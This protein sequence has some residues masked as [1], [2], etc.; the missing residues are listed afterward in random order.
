MKTGGGSSLDAGAGTVEGTRAIPNRK[1]TRVNTQNTT[2]TETKNVHL[3][4]TSLPD[5]NDA[6]VLRI[7]LAPSRSISESDRISELI[8][9]GD[10]EDG[11]AENFD[12]DGG[13]ARQDKTSLSVITCRA[14]IRC[15]SATS[16]LACRAVSKQR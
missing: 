14:W 15:E 9:S 12:E 11:F 2:N 13:D 4:H 16:T 7:R 5:E 10:G 8:K 3:M 6:I 1:K